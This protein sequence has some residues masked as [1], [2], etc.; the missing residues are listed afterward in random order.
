MKP[1]ILVVATDGFAK[2]IAH[3]MVNTDYGKAIAEAGGV[4]FVA[5]NPNLIYEYFSMADGLLLTDGPEVHRGR[6]GKYYAPSESLPL[7]NRERE[8][9]E[10][11]LC[12]MFSKSKK[13]I[14]GIGRGMQILNVFFGG[15]LCDN[16]EDASN[17]I[18][19]TESKAEFRRHFVTMDNKSYM[20]N[21]AHKS[22]IE[23]LGEELAATAYA[24]DNTIEAIKHCSLPIFGVQWHPE[25]K[26]ENDGISA[27]IFEDFITLCKEGWK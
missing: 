14:L 8:E 3:F 1:R 17:H 25:H 24:E 20:V 13:P 21:S 11:R 2:N 15:T 12:E 18:H 6:Y 23:K 27:K 4:P 5:L 19:L 26:S 9:M 16:I 7:L 22:V 10:L